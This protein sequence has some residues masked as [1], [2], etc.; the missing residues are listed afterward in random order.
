MTRPF[1]LAA[2]HTRYRAPVVDEFEYEGKDDSG[3]ELRVKLSERF[4]RTTAENM[5]R[6]WETTG[7]LCPIVIGHTVK[8]A[9]EID[10]PP[11]VG[12]LHNYDIEPFGPDAVP[13]LWADHWIRNEVTVPLNGVPMKLSHDDIAT[14]FPHRSGEI[15]LGMCEVHPHSL[16]GATAPHRPL[17]L[18]KLSEDGKGSVGYASPGDLKMADKPDADSGKAV[19]S[20]AKLD[21]LM[22]MVGQLLEAFQTALSSG[23]GAGAAPGGAPAEAPQGDHEMDQFLKSLEDESGEPEEEPE[24]KPKKKKEV[25]DDTVA[26]LERERDAAVLKLKRAEVTTALTELRDKH[27]VDVDPADEQTVTDLL[28]LPED[29]FQRTIARLQRNGKGKPPGDGSGGFDDAVRQQAATPP[30]GGKRKVATAEDKQKV[31]KLALSKSIDYLSA[32]KELG[33]EIQ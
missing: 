16:L 1:D 14:R 7:D 12:V 29:A 2:T 3:A 28:I 4:L 27:N 13:T 10:Q 23:G 26:K 6:K 32:A 30:T 5:N 17:G 25:E 8:G 24:A 19:N 9:K 18:L 15:W 11:K 22:G 31:V 20:D 21:Q 33:F